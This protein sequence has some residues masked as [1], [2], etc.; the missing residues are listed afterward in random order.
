[1]V[2]LVSGL[3]A[4]AFFLA[5]T[6]FSYDTTLYGFLIYEVSVGMLYPIYSK[7]KAEYLPASYRGTL[8]NIFK[9]PFNMIVIFLLLSM[10]KIFT[11]QQV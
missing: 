6:G 8:M 3:C 2:K 5:N 4:I 10:N 9:I 1:M 7:I 11:I